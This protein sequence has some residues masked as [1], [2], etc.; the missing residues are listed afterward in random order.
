MNA[1]I[2]RNPH[3]R[4]IIPLLA[5]MLLFVCGCLGYFLLSW[6]ITIQAVGYVP[7]GFQEGLEAGRQAGLSNPLFGI[8]P[9][10][11]LCSTIFFPILALGGGFLWI[12]SF[13]KKQVQPESGSAPD[14]TE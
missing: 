5:A 6:F 9:I 11:C 2:L 13:Q 1:D 8:A 14:D 12:D 3:A 7:Q 4:W 10:L